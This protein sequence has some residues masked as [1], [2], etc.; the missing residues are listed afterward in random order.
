MCT[1]AS[2]N[3]SRC[4]NVATHLGWGYGGPVV[5]GMNMSVSSSL[6]CWGLTRRAEL[7]VAEAVSGDEVREGRREIRHMHKAYIHVTF[8]L[9]TLLNCLQELPT[10]VHSY[11]G[12]FL[13]VIL[14]SP[15]C[16]QSTEHP[17]AGC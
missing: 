4:T 6:N 16:R 13:G 5:V 7:S 11:E 10:H 2:T 12:W 15:G 1:S 17:G 8:Q 9:L 3:G 14:Y